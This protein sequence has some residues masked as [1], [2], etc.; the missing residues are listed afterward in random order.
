M[1]LLENLYDKSPIFFQNIMV[2]LSGY[3]RNKTRYG[4]VYYDY[5]DFL[6]EFDKWS[7][8]EKLDFQREE[9][10]KFIQ[11]TVNNSK[12]YRNLYKDVDIESI[13]TIDDLKQLPIVEKEML[14]ENIN[15]VITIPYRGAIEGHTGGTTGKSLVVLFT[16]EDMMKR[17]AILD[18]FKARVGFVHRKM[19]RATFNGKHIIPPNQKKE[20]FWRYNASCKQM[21]YSSFHLTEKNMKYYIESLNKF[22]PHA[23]DGFFMSMCDIA[24]YIERHNIKLE[25]TPVAIFP[26]S[27]TL[28]KSGRELLERVFNCKVYDQYASSEGAPFVTECKNQVLHMELGSGV[29]EHVKADSDEIL[30]TS[31]T[32]HG[33]PLIRYRI[34]DSMVF[35][36]E[37]S[38]CHCGINAPVIKEI[39][40]RKLDFLYTSDGAKINGGNIANLFKNM[41]NALIRAQTI[42][43]KMG[44][45]VIKL[46]VDKKLYKP[47]YD[48]LL[49]DEFI[50]KFG[51][52]TKITIEHVPEIPREK[53]GKFR[54]IKNNVS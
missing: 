16:P 33:T 19:K 44:E 20:V 30:V 14:R 8:K 40:G 3:Q 26:T 42:Q 28:T 9:L 22:K 53:S 24:G 39:H 48:N 11:Y 41:P 23:I 21:I 1:G 15:D 54:M 29:F 37:N 4:K 46:E 52:N 31:F 12:F 13:R 2:T 49:K 6:S 34:G 38:S 7:L 36:T 43:D 32:T 5:L 17:M 50:H 18:H 45:I 51:L 35:G 47:E 25:F 27:E 10:V